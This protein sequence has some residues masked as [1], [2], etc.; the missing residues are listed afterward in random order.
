[1]L[2]ARADAADGAFERVRRDLA[3]AQREAA[4]GAR[5]LAN[6]HAEGASAGRQT[7][8]ANAE[9]AAASRQCAAAQ[10]D[11]AQLRA[12]L[13]ATMQQRN[14]AYAQQQQQP[15]AAAVAAERAA[16][17]AERVRN[18][19]GDNDGGA[20][21]G[22]YIGDEAIT[23]SGETPSTMTAMRPVIVN[24]TQ[25]AAL[26]SHLSAQT[27]ATTRATK[28]TLA[29]RYVAMLN[30]WAATVAPKACEVSFDGWLGSPAL[31]LGE[32]IYLAWY[33]LL[34]ELPPS[35]LTESLK[36]PVAAA[37]NQFDA[38]AESAIAEAIEAS[39]KRQGG[40]G[41]QAQGR[42]RSGRRGRG[43]GRTA[44][45]NSR[46]SGNGGEGKA[47]GQTAKRA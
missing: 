10:A 31:A 41:G 24:P 45:Q 40:S 3:E 15:S 38:H 2:K 11:V 35:L 14:A 36:G 17:V 27:T 8:N 22:N 33:E 43:R 37:K 4:A 5:A 12:Q 46:G 30:L 28:A 6:A 18:Q 32:K 34:K 16:E 9:A 42:G 7:A 47:R 13:E 21:E 25:R 26:I 23:F 19:R 44:S 20:C 1:V 29:N 39:R